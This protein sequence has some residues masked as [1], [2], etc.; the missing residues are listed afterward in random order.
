M[1]SGISF[2]INYWMVNLLTKYRV[3]S[4]KVSH[5]FWFGVVRPSRSK[6]EKNNAFT[7]VTQSRLQIVIE[8]MALLF[9]VKNCITI[10]KVSWSN[11]RVAQKYRICCKIE[12]LSNFPL[13]AKNRKLLSACIVSP[14][15]S[16]RRSLFF[17]HL[18]R[19]GQYQ[20]RCILGPHKPILWIFNLFNR[21][22]E[23]DK[24]Q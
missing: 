16:D 10:E 15:L 11:F 7:S 4:Y 12:V 19:Q 24:W 17:S 6:W 20:R 21:M 2:L 13:L 5:E 22:A 9:E 8:N 23:R 1:I 14:L 18:L 3:K